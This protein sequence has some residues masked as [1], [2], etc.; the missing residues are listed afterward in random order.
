[1]PSDLPPARIHG[2]PHRTVLPGGTRVWRVHKKAYPG[3][4]FNPVDADEHFGGGRFD[5]TPSD[6]YPYFYAA[7]SE[8]TALAEVFLRGLPFPNR[9]RRVLQRRAVE[10]R[11]LSAVELTDELTLLT[12]VS[13]ADLAAVSQDDWLVQAE[14]REYAQTRRWAHW[15]R[16]QANWAQGFVW[17]SKRNIPERAVILFGDRCHPGTLRP[18]ALPAIDLDDAVGAEWLNNAL[19]PF[20]VTIRPPRKH[21]RAA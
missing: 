19:A 12:L 9:G 7:F 17:Q 11:R 3:H 20:H 8:V 14:A 15:L 18:A 21:V 16:D 6:S 4:T 5:S 10:D 13:S 2:T 1:M